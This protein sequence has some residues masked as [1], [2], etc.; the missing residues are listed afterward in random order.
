MNASRRRKQSVGTELSYHSVRKGWKHQEPL[1]AWPIGEPEWTRPDV[2]LAEEH[3]WRRQR[4]GW[5]YIGMRG[6]HRDKFNRASRTNCQQDSQP[7]LKP[8]GCPEKEVTAKSTSPRRSPCL[9]Q[10]D[11]AGDSRRLPLSMKSDR[12]MAHSLS[13]KNC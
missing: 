5:Y 7:S 12:R 11:A 13:V 8:A 1:E 2:G 6:A 9:S 10:P 4:T 3:G